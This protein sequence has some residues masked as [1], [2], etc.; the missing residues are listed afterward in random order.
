[1]QIGVSF[2]WAEGYSKY[3]QVNPN[4]SVRLE[5]IKNL[6]FDFNY[7]Y[8]YKEMLDNNIYK[9]SFFFIKGS[10]NF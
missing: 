4:L 5:I 10:Y 7:Q 3:Y 8:R 9:S 1:M 2:G 6:F